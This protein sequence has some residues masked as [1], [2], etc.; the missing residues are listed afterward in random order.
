MKSDLKLFGPAHLLILILIPLLAAGL[1]FYCRRSS[2]AARLIRYSLAAFLAVNELIWYGYVLRFQGIHFPNG[3][4]LD[5]CDVTLWVT[6]VAAFSLRPW[7]FDIVYYT[8]IAGTGMALLTPDLWMPLWSYPIMAFFLG[9]GITVVT[10]LTLLWGGAAKPRPGS[11]WRV[12]G[13]LNLYAA[14]VGLFDTIFKTNY[15]YLRQKPA[16]AS[17]LDFLG[18]WPVYL[19]GGEAV[20]LAL[21]WLLWLPVRR[22]ASPARKGIS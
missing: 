17:L 14:A 1:A 13:I 22:P 2:R 12:F 3:L 6:V 18:P 5:L 20:A 11:V 4:A 19:L 15:M 16:G 7:L 21:F 8:A 10:V 9:H